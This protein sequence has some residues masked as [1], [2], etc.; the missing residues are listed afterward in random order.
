L[1]SKIFEATEA[2]SIDFASYTFTKKNSSSAAWWRR[3][4]APGRR[5]LETCFVWGGVDGFQCQADTGA[6]VK[7]LKKGDG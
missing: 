5:S 7:K 2:I 4:P 6:V 1:L 3:K